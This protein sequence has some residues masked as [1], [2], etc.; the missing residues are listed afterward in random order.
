MAASRR[1]HPR[2]FAWVKVQ[3]AP[4]QRR[5]ARWQRRFVTWQRRF[6]TWQRRLA[7]WQRRFARWQRRLARWQRRLA[8]WQRR[9][10][11]WQ[12]RFATWQCRLARWQIHPSTGPCRLATRHFQSAA[13]QMEPYRGPPRSA[14]CAALPR[15][16][17]AGPR[18]LL[19]TYYAFVAWRRSFPGCRQLESGGFLSSAGSAALLRRLKCVFSVCQALLWVGSSGRP[20]L[21]FKRPIGYAGLKRKG[22][23]TLPS[24]SRLRSG[25]M[26]LWI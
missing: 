3:S 12:R 14:S 26:L 25:E 7:T 18:D 8:R 2:H 24:T 11:T 15:H 6:A 20:P 4:W 13:W 16:D 21:A 5:L 22:V 1:T 9:F 17:Q 19:N 23:E 10:A